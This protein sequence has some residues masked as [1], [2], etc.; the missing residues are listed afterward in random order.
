MNKD[1]I[2]I[3]NKYALRIIN[4]SNFQVK[5]EILIPNISFISK[6]RDNTIIIGTKEGIKRIN[7]KDFERISLI[8]KIYSTGTYL[9]MPEKFNLVYE[10]SDKR[11]A[12]CSSYGNIQICKFKI[13]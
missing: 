10:F 2:L 7:L 12:I 11:S 1:E 5:M 9:N 4:I 8:N 13:A 3:A 6:L